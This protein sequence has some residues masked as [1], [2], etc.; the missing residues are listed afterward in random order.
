MTMFGPNLF[1]LWTPRPSGP[2]S[3]TTVTP[4]AILTLGTS[5]KTVSHMVKVEG[6][7]EKFDEFRDILIPSPTLHPIE[8]CK[9]VTVGFPTRRPK[10]TPEKGAPLGPSG[11]PAKQRI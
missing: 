9:K 11:N 1:S 3:E 8:T 4:V 2:V 7:M 5:G 10:T 6:C